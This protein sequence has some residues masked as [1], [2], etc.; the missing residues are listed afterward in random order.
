[1]LS[2][3][4]IDQPMKMREISRVVDKKPQVNNRLNIIIVD[5]FRMVDIDIINKVIR[6]FNTAPRQ[7]KYLN[8]PEYAH[9]AERNKEFYL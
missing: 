2:W 5:E 1:M 4:G 6:K 7:P 8:K 3:V 9:L